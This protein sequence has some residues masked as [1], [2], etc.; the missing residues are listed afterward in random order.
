MEKSRFFERPSGLTVAEIIT[1]T[2]AETGE[3]ALLSHRITGVAPVDLAGP[4]DL[5]FIESSKFVDALA[6]TRAGACLMPPRFEERAPE[7]LIVLRTKEPYRAFVTVHRQLYPQSLYPTSLFETVGIYHGA[8]IHPT[9]R[10]ESDV[11]VDPGAVIGPRAE[12]GGGSVIAAAAV[13]GPDVLIG[14]NCKIGAGCSITH[15][16][17]G[18]RVIIHPGC[19]IGQDGFGYT[20]DAG[21]QKIPQTGRVIIQNDVEIGAA[22]TIDRGH[23]GHRDRASQ[24]DRQFMPDRPQRR[25]RPALHRSGAIG[26]EWQRDARGLRRARRV[27]WPCTACYDRQRS[28]GGRALRHH[29]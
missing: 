11:T 9:A 4:S 1:L 18:D 12:I 10:L 21:Q 7:G 8:T 24:Q 19:R 28:A 22:T 16:L 6:T 2:G 15:A 26:I 5:T 29:A 14:R 25:Y 17:I 3:L 23:Q 20:T 13:I 27:R